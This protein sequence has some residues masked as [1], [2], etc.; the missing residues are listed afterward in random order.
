MTLEQVIDNIKKIVVSEDFTK[1]VICAFED[2]NFEGKTEVIVSND[3][4][5]PN[6]DYQAYVNH[7]DAPI[8][9]I[10]ITNDKVDAWEA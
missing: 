5:N 2:Y 7:K 9:C 10:K 4:A 3:E 6:I 1:D 8:I